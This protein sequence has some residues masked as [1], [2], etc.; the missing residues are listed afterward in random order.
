MAQFRQ[1]LANLTS[2]GGSHR[3]LAEKYRAILDSI[4]T[5][6]EDEL[7]E[8]LKAFIEAIVNENV[9]LVISRQLLSE[10][11]S[12]LVQLEDSV[13][14]AVSHFT[15]EVV[16]PR[17]IS[18]EDQVGAI[19]Q[20][21]ADIY[22][23][24]Q[25]WCQAAKVLVG[26][27]LETG[28]KQYSVDYKLETYL[29]IA[30]LYLE[31]EDPVQGEAYINRAAQLQ[32]QTKNDDLQIIYKVCQGRVLDYKRKFIEAASR[33]NELSYKTAIHDS[34]RITALKNATICTIL[35]AAGQQRSR[36]LATLYKDERCQQL[37]CFN[38]LEKMYLDRLIK[39]TELT[40]FETL[41]QAHQKALTADGSTILEHAV[42]E[43]NLL[44]A[45]KLYNNITFEGL[46]AL[47]E[48]APNKAERIASRMITEERMHGHIDQI[49][50]V[51]HF[52]TRQMLDT[53]D[54][55]IQS[56]C[57]QVNSVID[58]ITTKEPEWLNKTMEA[59]MVS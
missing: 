25:N 24:E 16:Q 15:L 6:G 34:E 49:D 53:W 57:F 36:M 8:G 14:K 48:I 20:H 55:Q 35:A 56:L 10:V 9:S 27:P 44:A 54:K 31:D 23:R 22:E 12:T 52:E 46:G 19:R 41:L 33:Y 21:L 2:S 58:K 38:I 30:R 18:F 50:S 28:Q 39:R 37:S 3:D 43:H 45:S 1:Q 7:V 5:F 47:L 29:K 26:I 4:L 32:T 13:S 40:E 42:I 59:Q 11:G 51:V 17:V